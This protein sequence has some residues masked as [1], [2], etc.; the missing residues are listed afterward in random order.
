LMALA[1]LVSSRVSRAHAEIA[2][3]R[4]ARTSLS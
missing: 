1:V 4:S 2:G 3:I